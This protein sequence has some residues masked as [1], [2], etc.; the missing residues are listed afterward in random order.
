M[1]TLSR[2]CARQ[3]RASPLPVGQLGSQ[4]QRIYGHPQPGPCRAPPL[5]PPAP[6]GTSGPALRSRALPSSSAPAAAA[7][8]MLPW[9]RSKFVLVEDESK[10]KGK[11]LSP[12]LAYTS[13]LSTF[14]RSCPDLL[15]DW[16]LERLG[17]VFR[18]RRQ[19]VEL[20]KEDPTYTVWYLGN[21]VTLHAKGDGCTDDAVGKIWAR[22]GPAG[23]TKMKL[24]LGPH[25]IRMQP[26]ERGGGS[27]ARRPAHAYLLPRITYCAADRRHPRVFAW[28]YRHQARH[29]AVVLR[30]HAV[31]LARAHKARALARLLRQ[32]ALAAFTDFKRLQRQSDARHVRQ[33][34]LRAAA[35]AAA[36]SVP[37]APL[38]RLLNAKCA[39][40]PPAAERGR[41][42][43]RLSSIQEEDEEEQEEEEEEEE[44]EPERERSSE[45]R[46]VRGP[47]RERPEVLSLARELRT[48]SLRGSAAATSRAPAPTPP[49]KGCLPALKRPTLDSAARQPLPGP[50]PPRQA[51]CVVGGW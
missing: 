49:H 43:P 41:G 30:C 14:L 9:R 13:L 8:T 44:E 28:V 25:G 11:S 7:A 3:H 35:G 12:R 39:Y 24:T 36:A 1:P 48:C 26:C 2:R 20:N 16:P 47:P 50:L 37:R 32:T 10:R 4:L 17:R 46:E 22:S 6:R 23:G 15:P 29:K 21:A 51:L 31:L 42:A 33:Q 34:H 45:R 5:L 27:G 18:S 19:K 40:R 38:R